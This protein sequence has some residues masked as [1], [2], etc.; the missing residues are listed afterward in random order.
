[1]NKTLIFLIIVILVGWLGFM[2]YLP[3]QII[4]CQIHFHVNNQFY[5]KQFYLVKQ[6]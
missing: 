4:Y 6:F 2:A 3:L 1:M 5:L